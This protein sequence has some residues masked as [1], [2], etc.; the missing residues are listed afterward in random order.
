MFLVNGKLQT[1]SPTAGL[2]AETAWRQLVSR[3]S[4]ARFFYAVLTTGVFAG[5]AA[6]AGCR[7]GRMCV[8]CS[9][10][11][12]REAGYRPCQRCTPGIACSSPL[13]RIRAHI[14]A[15]LDRAVP[16]AELGRLVGLSPFTVQRLFKRADGVSPLA[17]PESA[18]RGQS[19]RGIEA[20][21]D[22]D[23]RYLQCGI[24][25]VQPR[26]RGRATGH[27]ASAL[28]AGRPR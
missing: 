27:D 16:L 24:R 12:A 25:L 10:E 4:S 13:E 7:C 19:A 18:A 15:H 21:R 6:R 22:C 1:D 26:L 20:R 11:A 14:E 2:D 17:I 9:A 8:F 28:C 3:D 23:Q 5:Q